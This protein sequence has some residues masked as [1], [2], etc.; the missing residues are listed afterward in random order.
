[1]RRDRLLRR[2]MGLI[3]EVAM[4]SKGTFKYIVYHSNTTFFVMVHFILWVLWAMRRSTDQVVCELNR[5][6]VTDLWR[7]QFLLP[8]VSLGLI[9][10]GAVVGLA[11]CVCRSLYPALGTGAL[12][13]LAGKS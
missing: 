4:D 13:L 2:A 5:L 12:H 9:F 3:V 6:S 1:M 8:L 10:F 11:G 7:S